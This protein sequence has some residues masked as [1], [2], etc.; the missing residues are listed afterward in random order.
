ML[1]FG[2]EEL[3]LFDFTQWERGKRGLARFG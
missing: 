1:T 3:T 2:E